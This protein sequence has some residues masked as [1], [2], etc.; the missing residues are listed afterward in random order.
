MLNKVAASVTVASLGASVLA[1]LSW[2]HPAIGYGNRR[3][4]GHGDL[5]TDL[6]SPLAIANDLI[7]GDGFLDRTGA[8]FSF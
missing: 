5:M 3:A 4:D 1:H 6:L 7:D 2:D 8:T